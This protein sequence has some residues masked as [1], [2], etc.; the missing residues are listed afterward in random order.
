MKLDRQSFSITT[1]RLV[2]TP[3]SLN[4]KEEMFREFT[5]EITKLMYPS[6]PKSIDE[7]ISF[8][9]ASINGFVERQEIVVAILHK[10]TREYLG[11]AGLH[12]INSRTPEL[13]IWI[14][15]R[16][17][18]NGYGREAIKALKEWADKNLLYD[19]V[20]YPVHIDNH[21]SRTIPES[22]GGIVKDEYDKMNQAGVMFRAVE[23]RIYPPEKF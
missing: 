15:K 12:Q 22:L 14:K 10:E 19:Y 20:K 23:Y 2:L 17:Q 6:T 11:N 13:G 21:V 8:I 4:Y 16:G 7:V 1:D 3:V 18:G 9:E 5:H